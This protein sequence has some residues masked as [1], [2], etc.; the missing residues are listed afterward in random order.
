MGH[1]RSRRGYV[2]LDLHKDEACTA[3]RSTP[4][5]DSGV[6]IAVTHALLLTQDDQKGADADL[7]PGI[8]NPA[9]PNYRSTSLHA[10]HTYT[11]A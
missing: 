5:D 9:W 2:A 3:S 10:L 1:E 11:S 7:P 6:P 4:G 8:I